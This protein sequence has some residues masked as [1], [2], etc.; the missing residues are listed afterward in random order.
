LIIALS[1]DDATYADIEAKLDALTTRRNAL[2]TEIIQL[3]DA[4]AFHAA[5]LDTGTTFF[6]VRAAQ[7]LLTDANQL[8]Q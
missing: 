2:A 3:L 5:P 8:A 6:L 4:A 7:Q 1:G